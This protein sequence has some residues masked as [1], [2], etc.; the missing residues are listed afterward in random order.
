MKFTPN[1][2]LLIFC[3]CLYINGQAQNQNKIDSLENE[4]FKRS[5]D[6]TT[7]V[8]IY[9]SV[10]FEYRSSAPQKAQKYLDSSIKLSEK[11][12]YKYGLSGAY[13]RYGLI[14]KY[15][16][17]FD[18]AIYYYQKS[19]DIAEDLGDNN[20]IANVV[21]NLGNIYRMQ[22]DPVNATKAF[23]KA[24]RL[25]EKDH[26]VLGAAAAYSNLAYVYTDQKNYQLA[27]ENNRNAIKNFALAKD[28]FELARS[29]GMMCYIYYYQDYY[30]SA[31]YYSTKALKIFERL[32]DQAETSVLLNNT[33]NILT[34]NGKAA[35]SIPY[36]NKALE[37]QTAYKDS[38]GIYTSY[39]SLAQSYHFLGQHTK[40]ERYGEEA[41]AIL[42]RMGGVI[43][44]YI[45]AY[46]LI[47]KI[48][49]A[50][51]KH[52]K[53]YNAYEQF[54]IL[55]DSLINE[56]NNRAITEMQEKYES[57]KKD[58][59]LEKKQLEISNAKIKIRQKNIIAI[60]L[61]FLLILIII[62]SYL[63]YNRFKLRKQQELNK[64][65]IRQQNIRSKAVI[66]AE[67]KERTRIAKDLHDGV[68]QQLSAAKMIA[69]ALPQTN[70]IDEQTERMQVLQK[71]LD[72]AIK[73]VRSVS[74]DMM[75]NVLFKLGLASAIR[76]FLNKISV[77][78]I[79]KIDLQI[80]GL[81]S[82]LDKTT[83]IILYRVMQ[84][85]VNN[86][87]KHAD[88]NQLSIQVIEHDDNTLNITVEDDGKGFDAGNM[89]I[90][91]GIGLKNIISRIKYLNGTVEFDS[92]PGRGTTVIIDVP[93]KK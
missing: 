72:D 69:T 20:L 34:E 74:H 84:E 48:Y 1:Y 2:L 43:N 9:N 55:K 39:L 67:E 44:M 38:T 11:L 41:L 21:N 3:A 64:E 53:A 78:G 81:E 60:A 52:N 59:Q 68:G 70:D 46:D 19:I 62:T 40:A 8:D 93:I 92:V 13:N 77:A 90:F 26:D 25:R 79:L 82:G 51:G 22:A 28:S 32:G 47:A 80:L 57:D 31:I 88:A 5:L 63:L 23:L 86:I 37:I 89:E 73:E 50:T 65:V 27:I 36:H 61:V 14:Y 66:E 56:N 16:Y 54:N 58:L 91:N 87:I 10:A 85:L 49:R 17:Q 71:T 24:L 75:P 76:E 33:G 83:E 18:S 4:L 15:K 29:Y 6:D 45:D 35:E 30:D 7:K 12:D 42:D